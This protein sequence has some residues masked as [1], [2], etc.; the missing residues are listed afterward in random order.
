MSFWGHSE[1]KYTDLIAAAS[2]ARWRLLRGIKN[3]FESNQRLR[4]LFGTVKNARSWI[5]RIDYSQPQNIH[6]KRTDCDGRRGTAHRSPLWHA[7]SQTICYCRQRSNRCPAKEDQW[8]LTIS[9]LK[10]SQMVNRLPGTRDGM[11][12]SH[13]WQNEDRRGNTLVMGVLDENEESRWSEQF[14]YRKRCIRKANLNALRCSVKVVLVAR[15]FTEHM[16]SMLS[17]S[18]QPYWVAA[19]LTLQLAKPRIMTFCTCYHW[20]WHGSKENHRSTLLKGR[21]HLQIVNIIR[22]MSSKSM[23]KA[24]CELVAE[25]NDNKVGLFQQI[26]K[27]T[28]QIRLYRS[29]QSKPTGQVGKS[30]AK[31][32]VPLAHKPVQRFW[33][34]KVILLYLFRF[35]KHSRIERRRS[36]RLNWHILRV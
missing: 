15:F 10:P 21:L 2:S 4:E 19:G 29:I 8:L 28:Y 26:Q 11:N 1:P 30:T 27:K 5:I 35:S 9:H 14:P 23:I 12:R 18:T 16:S 3:H 13:D 31:F 36:T 25:A 7:D 17:T 22:Q 34:V 6:G 20:N 32:E 33:E 24:W